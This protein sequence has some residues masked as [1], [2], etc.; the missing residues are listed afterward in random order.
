MDITRCEEATVV[1]PDLAA[2]ITWLSA[3]EDGDTCFLH[4]EVAQ[5]YL[6]FVAQDDGPPGTR[7]ARFVSTHRHRFAPASS[8]AALARFAEY[9]TAVGRPLTAEG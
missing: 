9:R 5:D 7:G 4:C 2:F 3:R 1:A 8:R 6:R